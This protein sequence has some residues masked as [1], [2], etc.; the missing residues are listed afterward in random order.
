VCA[1][2]WE[3]RCLVC[4]AADSFLQ[5]QCSHCNASLEWVPNTAERCPQCAADISVKDVI[6][7]FTPGGDP[8]DD[9]DM[10]YCGECE[11]AD[12]MSVVPLGDGYFCCNCL[13]MHDR[14][15]QCE[16]CTTPIAG[17]GPDTY[18]TGCAFCDGRLGYDD[19]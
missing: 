17:V 14:L 8:K 16:W 15:D 6:N 18:L 10:S 1:P 9:P 2:L 12:E 13:A 4:E 3:G 5:L 19:D 11:F 7:E